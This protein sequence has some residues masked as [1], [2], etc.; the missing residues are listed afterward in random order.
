RYHDK[1]ETARLRRLNR[2]IPDLLR[3]IRIVS[4]YLPPEYRRNAGRSLLDWFADLDLRLAAE[5]FYKHELGQGIASFRR[6][7][8]LRPSL[9]FS[10][11]ALKYSKWAVKIGVG[12]IF[13][14]GWELPP[15][16]RPRDPGEHH[17]ATA[18]PGADGASRE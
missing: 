16:G 4:G 2:D 11:T 6:A 8:R 13:T 10:R 12:K 7:A 1:N 14:P 18:A 5:A 3:A 17:A 15:G 9:I